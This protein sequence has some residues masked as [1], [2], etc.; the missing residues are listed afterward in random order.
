MNLATWLLEQHKSLPE[1]YAASKG[2]VLGVDPTTRSGHV[3]ILNAHGGCMFHT[4]GDWGWTTA[5]WCDYLS[6]ALMSHPSVLV[7]IESNAWR[8]AINNSLDLLKTAEMGGRFAG[9]AIGLGIPTVCPPATAI[10]YQLLGY[11]GNDA[12]IKQALEARG[13]LPEGRT[14]V[15]ARDGLAAAIAIRE[16]LEQM[17]K[18]RTF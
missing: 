10:R 5:E 8:P 17:S 4:V 18:R 12:A 15:G 16:C 13:V 7:V 1:L 2:T 3:G 14:N 6:V 9:V 11:Q